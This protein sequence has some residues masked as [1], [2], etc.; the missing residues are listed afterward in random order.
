MQKRIVIA[1]RNGKKIFGDWY[2]VDEKSPISFPKYSKHTQQDNN[3]LTKLLDRVKIKAIEY[4]SWY[5]E[6][7]S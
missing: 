5:V 6:E 1:N 2:E 7:R 4:Q 3:Q